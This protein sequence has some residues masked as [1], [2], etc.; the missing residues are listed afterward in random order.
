MN[1]LTNNS[2]VKV[3]LSVQ[4]EGDEYTVGDPNIN[5]FIR[6]P[7]EAVLVLN[8]LNGEKNVND[9]QKY[10]MEQKGLEIDVLDFISSLLELQLV[11][12]IDGEI[13]SNNLRTNI[14]PPNKIALK[15]GKILFNKLFLYLYGF[16]SVTTVL[17]LVFNPRFIPSYK[18]IFVLND[19]GLN[20]AIFFIVSWILNFTHE[21]AHYL[22]SIRYE[23]PVKFNLSLRLYWLVIEADMTGL[24]SI[25]KNK[26]YV[27]YLAGMAWDFVILFLALMIQI[28]CTDFA[29]LS[30][31]ASM[32]SLILIFRSIWQFLVFLRTDVYYVI[33][34]MINS[35]NIHGNS[36]LYLL[37]TFGKHYENEWNQLSSSEQ[38]Y[39]KY[40]CFTYVIGATLALA[41]LVFYSLPGTYL[42]VKLA[43]TQILNNSIDTYKFF[44]GFLTILVILLNIILW[45]I[46][47]VNKIKTIRSRNF[48]DNVLT[49]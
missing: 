36:K 26:R 38:F 37:K 43:V 31:F 20:M 24:W 7:L 9:I 13:I 10:L 18:D 30:K 22:A 19:V 41:L 23:I 29:Y 33:I 6:V 4:K 27:A 14:D 17:F 11:Y 2:I 28:F 44:D 15:I 48:D 12:S 47:A 8:E 39:A 35:T 16:I 46:G 3:N 49:T 42:T 25:S 1:E 21:S 32:I 5:V 45:C 40:F 34:N